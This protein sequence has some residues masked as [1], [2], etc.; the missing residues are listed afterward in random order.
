MESPF[1][2]RFELAAYLHIPEHQARE[3]C[4][5]HG[6]LPINADTRSRK[7]RGNRAKYC[8]A[9][10]AR[11]Q[12]DK[13]RTLENRKKAA[14]AQEPQ[15]EMPPL[16]DFLLNPPPA[17]KIR[18]DRMHAWITPDVCGTRG[19]CQGKPLCPN[20]PGGRGC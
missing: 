14:K 8:P 11:I 9:C 2:D 18:C 12:L 6:V 17:E 5:R 19:E 1:M 7:T 13:L 4:A 20:L 3:L 15:P 16:V 10:A